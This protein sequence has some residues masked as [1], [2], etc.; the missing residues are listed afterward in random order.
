MVEIR[1]ESVQTYGEGCIDVSN[2]Q[3]CFHLCTFET[4]DFENNCHLSLEHKL[5]MQQMASRHFDY[6]QHLS[7][8]WSF[9][10]WRSFYTRWNGCVYATCRIWKVN[11]IYNHSQ[12]VAVIKTQL[13][14]GTSHSDWQPHAEVHGCFLTV[15]N[16]LPWVWWR[17]TGSGNHCR[18]NVGALLNSTNQAR[19]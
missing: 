16:F 15:S 5:V 2:V 1:R 12:C 18:W 9:Q 19:E 8:E 3:R 10:S 4:R 14:V 13:W 17:H 6:R 11:R 7:W